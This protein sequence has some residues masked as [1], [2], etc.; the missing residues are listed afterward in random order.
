MKDSNNTSLTIRTKVAS[1]LNSSISSLTPLVR[2]N[3]FGNRHSTGT[4]TTAAASAGNPHNNSD[5]EFELPLGNL[6]IDLDADIEKSNE[7]FSGENSESHH[8]A[9]AGNQ[10]PA[11]SGSTSNSLSNAI[12]N[13]TSNQSPAGSS[14]FEAAKAMSTSKTIRD[15]NNGT[16]NSNS[17]QQQNNQSN[18]ATQSNSLS[19]SSA[20][21]GGKS[22]S[23][24]NIQPLTVDKRQDLKLKIKRKNT[25]G[26]SSES[27]LEVVQS[28]TNPRHN[29]SNSS[30]SYG[31]SSS[32]SADKN[33]LN[34]ANNGAAANS[35]TNE[36]E[37]IKH[38]SSKSKNSSHKEKKEKKDKADKN[39]S[40][41]SS[42]KNSN[43]AFAGAASF[44]NSE[45]AKE[46]NPIVLNFDKKALNQ[47]SASDHHHTFNQLKKDADESVDSPP[48]KKS[49]NDVSCLRLSAEISAPINQLI[50]HFA[51][52]LL[53][54]NKNTQPS[55]SSLNHCTNSTNKPEMRTVSTGT[56]MSTMT[57]PECLG[58]CEPGSSICLE[59]I[60]WVET[61]GEL[62]YWSS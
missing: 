7:R 15:V 22:S 4:L 2:T 38:S 45:T 40:N 20:P 17:T 5:D 48:F 26:K 33:G 25:G 8:F 32:S 44:N 24:T 49:K 61:E 50:N 43:D 31:K 19:N 62:S 16:T 39:S 55:S 58:Y 46:R 56:D 28:D 41:S 30:S 13:S 53:Q 51:L 29:S 1:N 34:L 37:K 27:K 23:S 21:S 12:A 59:G 60:T 42:A 14:P 9:T 57:E 35:A 47:S 10:P 11:A 54:N 6:I 18:S 3:K 36:V 52:S